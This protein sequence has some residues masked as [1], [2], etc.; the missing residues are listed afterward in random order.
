VHRPLYRLYS[1]EYVYNLEY[2]SKR[3][4]TTKGDIVR[5]SS[6]NDNCNWIPKYARHELGVIL[7]RFKIIKHK[8]RIFRDY[9]SRVL[10]ITGPGKGREVT[11]CSSNIYSKRL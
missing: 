11:L 2:K 3:L 6:C 4:G 1:K 9:F 5:I 7:T 8:G 10:L